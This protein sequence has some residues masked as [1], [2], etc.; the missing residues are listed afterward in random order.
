MRL[1]WV[2]A[3]SA[4]V[5]CITG[6]ETASEAKYSEFVKTVNF[7]NLDTFYYKHTMISGMS[8]RKSEEFMLE[9]LSEQALTDEMSARGF[10]AV[11][12]AGGGSDFFVVTK[13]RKAVSNYTHTFNSVDG[14]A[15]SLGRREMDFKTMSRVSVIVEIY[16]TSSGDLFWRKE[17]YNAFE[18]IQLT[19][20]RI[21]RTLQQAVQNFPE[22]IKKDPNLPIIQ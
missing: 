9:N 6:C 4:V 15:A 22:H 7:S 20:V 19:E 21:S 16:E 8:F 14:S 18:A 17:M 10:Q 2:M 5:V 3:T 1:I 12:A 11:D 13:W